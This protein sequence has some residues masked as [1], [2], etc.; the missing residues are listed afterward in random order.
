MV[1]NLPFR[2]TNN[3][4]DSYISILRHVRIWLIVTRW[5][6]VYPFCQTTV[7][8][9]KKWNYLIRL[10]ILL[11]NALIIMMNISRI[12]Y[13]KNVTYM[14]KQTRDEC[15]F[16]FFNYKIMMHFFFLQQNLIDED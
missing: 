4:A 9:T 15:T 5:N 14:T 2:I 8:Q 3:R 12:T 7:T 1:I 16:M 13:V 11:E 6:S 10:Y